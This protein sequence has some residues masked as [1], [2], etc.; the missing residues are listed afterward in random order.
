MERLENLCLIPYE[1]GF[2]LQLVVT[3]RRAHPTSNPL[4][5]G[6][7]GFPGVKRLERQANNVHEFSEKLQKAGL[8]SQQEGQG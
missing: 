2:F 8:T 6:E 1:K 3:G 7:F 4:C 5:M